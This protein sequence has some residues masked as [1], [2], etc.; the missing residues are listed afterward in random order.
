M[1]TAREVAEAYYNAFNQGDYAKMLSLVDPN[2]R[3][4]PNQGDPRIGREKLAAFLASNDECYREQLSNFT[5][6]TEPSGL[7]VAVDFEVTGMYLKQADDTMP[8]ALEQVYSIQVVAIIEVE[9]GLITVIRTYYNLA[10]WLQRVGDK[11]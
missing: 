5:F 9:N 10:D 7:K 3:H 2:V 8:P 6:L 1:L 11:H 4:E